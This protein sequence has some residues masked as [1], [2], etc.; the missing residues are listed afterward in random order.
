MEIK[1]IELFGC[2]RLS[3]HTIQTVLK[4]ISKFGSESE[5]ENA[6]SFPSYI[7]SSIPCE[8]IWD[9]WDKLLLKL[10]FGFRQALF[11][12]LSYT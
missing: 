5:H 11:Q 2:K 7:G 1:K 6:C 4:K 12:E 8:T 3:A 9:I 10:H